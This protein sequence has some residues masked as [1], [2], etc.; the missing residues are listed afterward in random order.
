MMRQY[1]PFF[2][3]N[4]RALMRLGSAGCDGSGIALGQSVGGAVDMMDKVYAARNVAP[5]NAL[6]DGVLIN[7]AGKR[8][9]NE[10]AYSG[11]LGLAIAEQTHGKAWLVL[12][13][14]SF[15]KAIKQSIT[16]GMLFF[17]FYGVPALLNMLLG[18]TKRAGDLQTLARK[19]GIDSKAFVETMESYHRP[20]KNGG[21][22][23]LGRPGENRKSLHAGPYYA[24][25]MSIP[26]VYAFTYFFTLGGLVVDE[27]TG[28]VKRADGTTIDGLYA[29]GRA[30]VGLCSNGY[31]SGLSIGDGMFSG[32]RVGRASALGAALEPRHVRDQLMH[33]ARTDPSVG[34][35]S[36]TKIACSKTGK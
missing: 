3:Q 11:L 6:L 1:Q 23:E 15:R 19:C 9:V 36:T 28:A 29:A 21:T 22:D 7:E 31:I 26:N 10:D 33:T 18:G 16:S 20:I 8:F 13:A 2:A 34:T 14:A 12:P 30:A 5:P 24:I 17:K 32:R 4:Y 27:D 25:N 35:V